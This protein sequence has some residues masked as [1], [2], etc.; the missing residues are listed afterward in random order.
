LDNELFDAIKAKDVLKVIRLIDTG[1][2]VNLK[3]KSKKLSLMRE[4]I[5]TKRSSKFSVGK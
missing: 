5:M 3:S 1:A 4:K 2:D